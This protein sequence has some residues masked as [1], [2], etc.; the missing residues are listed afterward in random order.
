[1]KKVINIFLILVVAYIFI[2]TGSMLWSH[3]NLGGIMISNKFDIAT[4]GIF[5]LP[6]YLGIVLYYFL[7]QK[8]IF[9]ILGQ[10][11]TLIFFWLLIVSLKKIIPQS[12]Q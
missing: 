9:F 3:Y 2:G 11:F 6:C 1:M 8:I 4:Q 5:N 12:H 10:L 7:G